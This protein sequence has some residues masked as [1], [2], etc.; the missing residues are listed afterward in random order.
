MGQQPEVVE[1]PKVS[2]HLMRGSSDLLVLRPKTS[3]SPST[4]LCLIPHVESISKPSKNLPT[5]STSPWSAPPLPSAWTSMTAACSWF[6]W[7][8]PVLPLPQVCPP[9][10]NL[11]VLWA[12]V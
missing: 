5:L 9:Q 11:R 6:S 1:E 7:L 10:Q 3:G 4:P 2:P 12:W 8:P